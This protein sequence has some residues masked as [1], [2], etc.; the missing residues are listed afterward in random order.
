MIRRRVSSSTT[1][2]CVRTTARAIEH[3]RDGLKIFEA[4]QLTGIKPPTP[5]ERRFGHRGVHCPHI[6]LGEIEICNFFR[7]AKII[8][9]DLGCAATG[10]AP[11][12]I[13]G[14]ATEKAVE[15]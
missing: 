14:N 11:H 8:F 1:N 15:C 10:G 2:S 9:V 3:V 7:Y 5:T 6:D 4:V 13:Q 12:A